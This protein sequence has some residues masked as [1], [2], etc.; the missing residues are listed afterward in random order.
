MKK[1]NIKENYKDKKLNKISAYFKRIGEKET[2]NGTYIFEDGTTEEGC[3]YN[4]NYLSG[5]INFSNNEDHISISEFIEGLKNVNWASQVASS[6]DN[7]EGEGSSIDYD[8]EEFESFEEGDSD[9]CDYDA[10]TDPTSIS[11]YFGDEKI[12]FNL[13]DENL[14]EFK[15]VKYSKEDIIELVKHFNK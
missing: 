11:F 6:I 7:F 13:I 8:K 10:S 2:M 14:Y 3:S 1:N 5:T 15:D 12:E 4:N 9:G